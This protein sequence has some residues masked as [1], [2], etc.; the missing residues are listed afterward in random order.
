MS[1]SGHVIPVHDC[2][3]CVHR[4]AFALKYIDDLALWTST[5][6]RLAQDVPNEFFVPRQPCD[7]HH[8]A[9]QI[10]VEGNPITLSISVDR[11]IIETRDRLEEE[12]KKR[13][14]LGSKLKAKQVEYIAF[15]EQ[16]QSD[17]RDNADVECADWLERQKTMYLDAHN[18]V[19]GIEWLMTEISEV[20]A[21]EDTTLAELHDLRLRRGCTCCNK[22]LRHS[23]YSS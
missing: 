16:R 13:R 1:R 4:P 17:F 20:E 18:L 22:A 21:Q 11:S 12:D 23:A 14:D 5:Y 19:V 7:H 15:E 3:R 6:R 9:D 10:P 2:A 8:R